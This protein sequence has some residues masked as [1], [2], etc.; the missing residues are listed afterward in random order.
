MYF[1]RKLFSLGILF[2][3]LNRIGFEIL[4]YDE[5]NDSRLYYR[6]KSSDGQKFVESTVASAIGRKFYVSYVFEFK[7]FLK[8]FRFSFR[9]VQGY[10]IECGNLLPVNDEKYVLTSAVKRN[11][12][13]VARIVSAK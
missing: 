11:L 7:K 2:E 4:H 5:K 1:L 6:E 3:F 10:W 9:K 12:T 8:L 13:D